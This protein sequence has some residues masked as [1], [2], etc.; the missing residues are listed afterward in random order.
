M[1]LVSLA[2]IRPNPNEKATILAQ[3]LKLDEFS[4]FTKGS[5]REFL[6]FLSREFG[7]RARDGSAVSTPYKEYFAHVNAAY[8]RGVLIAC[9]AVTSE[10][11]PDKVVHGVINKC[12]NTF[13]NQYTPDEIRK[14]GD[15]AY[16]W[17]FL[18]EKIIEYY[19]PSPKDRRF[20]ELEEE[21]EKS[22]QV[23]HVAIDELLQRGEKIEDLVETSNDLSKKSK[24]FYK[25]AKRF[26]RC[27]TIL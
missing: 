18:E 21:M 2:M 4:Y 27:C 8:I 15:N 7:G 20:Q 1:H 24:V 12:L 10:D 19:Q 26:R 5:A 9:V 22:H 6:V 3:E 23:M 17:A 11:Y 14:G 25:R 13:G 16:K